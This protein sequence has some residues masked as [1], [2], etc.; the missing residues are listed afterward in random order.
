MHVPAAPLKGSTEIDLPGRIHPVLAMLAFL[1]M[2]AT[3]LI[4][5]ALLVEDL[6]PIPLV[7]IL[8]VV[9]VCCAMLSWTALQIMLGGKLIIE[10]DGLK[11]TRLLA[12]ENYPWSTLDACKVMPATGTLGDDALVD[13]DD[14][15]GLGLFIK[16]TDRKRAHDLDADIVLCAGDK[17]DVQN[18]MRIAQ[19]VQAGINRSKE[20]AK[21][22]M[23]R[24]PAPGQRQEFRP[25]RAPATKKP[26]AKI[27]PVAQFRNRG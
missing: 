10:Q 24:Q 14:R 9:L 17:I 7:V 5:L 3:I 8:G 13:A 25:R 15:V 6:P 23:A 22:S 19:K 27:D 11:V 20:P 16:G 26:A 21:R 12:E 2:M 4:A 1:P 18:L